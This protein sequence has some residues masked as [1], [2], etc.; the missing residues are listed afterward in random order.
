MLLKVVN[1]IYWRN[2]VEKIKSEIVHCAET[3][4]NRRKFNQCAKFRETISGIRRY[5]ERNADTQKFI[6]SRYDV[7]LF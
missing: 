2:F 4:T 6:K 3:E 5:K 7:V 1:N